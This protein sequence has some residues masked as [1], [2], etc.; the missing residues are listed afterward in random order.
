MNRAIQNFE[1]LAENALR[2][3]ALAL[4]EAGYGALHTGSTLMR[5]VHL[6]DDTLIIGDIEHPLG[7]RGVFFVGIGKCAAAGAAAIEEI[8]G[9]RLTGGIALDVANEK[10]HQFK[11]VELF[12]GTHPLPSEVNETATARIVG[13]LEGCTADDLVLMLISGG[14]ST[15]LCLPT[16]PMTCTDESTLFTALTAGGATIQELN[17]VRKHTSRARGGGLACA[18]YPAEVVSLIISDVPGN[19]IAS[20]SSGP[21]VRDVS[22][23]ADARAVL[24]KYGVELPA[25]GVLTETPKEEKYFERVTNT[26]FLT[27]SDALRA[28]QEEAT[29]RGYTATIMSDHVAG[30][31]REVGKAIL[32]T[33]HTIPSKT[34]LLYAGEST[35]TFASPEHGRG[36][37][38]PPKPVGE[39]G[40]NQ[41]MALTVLADIRPDELVLTFASDGHD[42]SD[43]AGAI[44]DA[45]T[46]AHAEEK[47]LS[48]D[49]SL[50]RHCSYDFFKASGDALMTGYTESNVSDII[51]A[52]KN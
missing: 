51:I 50:A 43:H 34:V 38:V 9:D 42:N 10:Q 45:T 41:E 16:A 14:G 32:E 12:L 13:M 33:L 15:L 46:R 21:T 25:T 44:A 23:V 1:T 7:D 3:D 30:E 36:G 52:I 40:R 49:E 22:T 26:L 47:E 17:T 28:M 27:N 8:L 35:V 48:I 24:A 18:A 11:K 4:A 2:L 20:I 29:K 19:D 31:A 5:T 37:L 39:G 6:E